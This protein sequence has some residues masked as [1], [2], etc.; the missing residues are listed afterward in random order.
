MKDVRKTFPQKRYFTIQTVIRSY[1]VMHK[2]IKKLDSF[3]KQIIKLSISPSDSIINTS[4][5]KEDYQNNS[6]I[7]SEI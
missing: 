1:E 5:D 3:S 4:A 2:F 6:L 7:D